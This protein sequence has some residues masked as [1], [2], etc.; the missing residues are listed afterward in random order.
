MCIFLHGI[1]KK[2]DFEQ[3]VKTDRKEEESFTWRCVNGKIVDTAN[4]CTSS[5][6]NLPAGEAGTLVI[7]SLLDTDTACTN[8]I[9]KPL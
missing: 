3:N 8:L 2:I 6:F 5:T 1:L 4:F 9:S 7:A